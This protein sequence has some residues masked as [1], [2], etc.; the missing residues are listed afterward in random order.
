MTDESQGQPLCWDRWASMVPD[1][2][3]LSDQPPE[4]TPGILTIETSPFAN[5][6]RQARSCLLSSGALPTGGILSRGGATPGPSSGILG[7][8]F[9]NRVVAKSQ[10]E[11]REP[12]IIVIE[13]FEDGAVPPLTSV[14]T[15]MTSANAAVEDGPGN[16][17]GQH[18]G[19]QDTGNSADLREGP[20]RAGC[21]SGGAAPEVEDLSAQPSTGPQD[22]V[23]SILK[24]ALERAFSGMG[25]ARCIDGRIQGPQLSDPVIVHSPVGLS[26]PEG[27][28]VSGGF[29]VAVGGPGVLEPQLTLAPGV[30]ERLQRGDDDISS[31]TSGIGTPSSGES[32]PELEPLSANPGPSYQL[33]STLGLGASNPNRPPANLRRASAP[34]I[35]IAP[36]FRAGVVFPR[37][38]LGEGPE[39]E[40]RIASGA[41]AS[42][43]AEAAGVVH[44]PWR[45]RRPPRP[46][47]ATVTRSQ[48]LRVLSD[49]SS[50]SG[51]VSE[52]SRLVSVQVFGQLALEDWSYQVGQLD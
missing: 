10:W 52:R 7:K 20:C 22:T 47:S 38:S 1:S 8:D 16:G 11:V 23:E 42:S 45:P 26:I 2:D 17:A 5:I 36:N 9:E 14:G 31:G 50:D 51:R 41:A 29:G 30:L 25:D 27:F 37:A 43:S 49:T 6:K 21:P 15:I 13:D 35:S 4:F 12:E 28:L 33:L 24:A 18:C 46:L 48:S 34:S 3:T 40:E 39:L 32:E 19:V 44:A